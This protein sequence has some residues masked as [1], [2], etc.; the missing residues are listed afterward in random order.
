MKKIF[1]FLLSGL[2][3]ILPSMTFA[4]NATDWNNNYY[5][6]G[7]MMGYYGGSGLWMVLGAILMVAIWIL[8][9]VAI[10]ALIMW[11]VDQM[12]RMGGKKK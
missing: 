8:I 2:L 12:K 6:Y 3:L 4:Q 7:G 5:R 9:I 10:I 11:I 1:F